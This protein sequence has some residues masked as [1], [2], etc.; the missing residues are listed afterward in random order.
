MNKVP[1]SECLVCAEVT[2]AVCVCCN[3][4]KD[5]SPTSGCGCNKYTKGCILFASSG[6][7]RCVIKFNKTM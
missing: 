4:A 3:T 7:W 2:A 5:S 1:E 6:C